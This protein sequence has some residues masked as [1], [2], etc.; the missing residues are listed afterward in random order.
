MKTTQKD[1]FYK[2]QHVRITTFA[3]GTCHLIRSFGNIGVVDTDEGLVL[4][5]ITGKQLGPKSHRGVREVTDKPIKYIIYSHGHFDHCFGF[6]PFI[7]EIK[8]KG[9]DMPKIIAHENCVERFKKY[10]MLDKYH[11]WINSKQFA[12]IQEEVR[13]LVSARETLDPT[14]ILYGNEDY[15]FKLGGIKFELYHDK[16]ETDDSLWMHV[17]EKNV[18]FSGDLII[19]GYPNVGNPYKVQRYPK[20]WAFAM[21]KMMRKDAEY[22]VPGHGRLIEGKKKVNNSLS[23]TAEAMHFVHDEV[24]KRLNQGKWF[25]QIYHEMLSIYPDRFKKHE[26][27]KEIY[28]CYR[29]AI[30]SVF[31]LYHGWYD[32]G[33][34]TDL[35]PSK[36]ADIAKEFL[37]LNGEDQ[38]FNHAKKLFEGGKLQLALHIL[39]VII[40][41]SNSDESNVFLD[42][43]K[44]KYKILKRLAKQDTSFIAFN[45]I[46]NGAN[47]IKDLLNK[48]E[49]KNA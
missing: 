7:D 9:W 42:A 17:P 22:V 37:K 15:V 36:S 5:D 30:H 38:Y 31:R 6:D 19:S 3:D 24:I 49:K 29:F 43:Y 33:N 34:P 12:S 47:E 23:I 4:F 18:I 32:S 44:L 25:E 21:E 27:L 2:N 8:E 1:I 48:L 46:N 40:K 13:G 10:K 39:D 45:I 11:A 16:G 20:H 26:M 41:G 35:F 14:I 28:G